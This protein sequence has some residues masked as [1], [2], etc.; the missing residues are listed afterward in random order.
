MPLSK[1]Y[2]TPRLAIE[3]IHH[4]NTGKVTKNRRASKGPIRTEL[5]WSFQKADEL[6]VAISFDSQIK[7]IQISCIETRITNQVD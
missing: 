3:A 6:E 7:N 1:R 5:A 2:L 4:Q